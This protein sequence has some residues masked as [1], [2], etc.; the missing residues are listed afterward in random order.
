[1]G[2]PEIVYKS[3]SGDKAVNNPN[4]PQSKPAN[5]EKAVKDAPKNK[6]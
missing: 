3:K 1:M 4:Q 5:S 2:E 6:A